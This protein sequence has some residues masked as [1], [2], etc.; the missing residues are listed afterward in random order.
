MSGVS[1]RPHL[2]LVP[3]PAARPDLRRT[4]RRDVVAYRIRV[5]IDGATPSIWR[6]L[7][8]RS[9]VTLDLLHQALQ[10]AFDWTASHLHRF[11][12]GGGAFDHDS[13]LFLCPYDVDDKEWDED[14]DGLPA[15]AT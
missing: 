15:A 11:S 1:E 2:R 3:E 10:V 13:Q 12:L 4:R 8:V 5:D 9:N 14:D 7:D 6:R